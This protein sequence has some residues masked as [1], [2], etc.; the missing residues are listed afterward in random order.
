MA[1]RVLI[2]LSHCVEEHDQLSL[3]S[4]LGYEC[5]SLGGYIDPAHPHEALRPGL[6]DVPCVR[7]VKDAV[8]AL[9]TDDNLGQAQARI[10]EPVLDW[11]GDS[12]VILFH[13]HLHRLFGQWD[14]LRDFRR[15]GGRIIWRTVGQSV[16]NNEA[17][18]APY[19]RDGLEVVRYSPR[20]RHIP[21]YVGED[22]LIRFYKDPLEWRGW[23]GET[24]VVTNFTQGLARRAVWCNVGFWLDATRGLPAQPAGPESEQ[25]P[26]G[27]GPLPLDEMKAQ[28]RKARAYLYTGTQPAS[29]TLG[30][31]EALMTGTPMIS[32]G[33]KHMQIF[34][35]YGEELFEAHELVLPSLWTDDP[36]QAGRALRE[37]LNDHDLARYI[38]ARQRERAIETFGKQQVAAAWRAY[39]G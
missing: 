34:Q 18:A 15:R 31:I 5:A 3:L 20:E 29:V 7:E 12:G 17:E 21:G 37:L 22:A 35:P 11:L 36:D 14:H 27:L 24:E 39:L 16:A 28:L 4:D 13:H 9:G 26:G 38:S 25:L 33:P 6:P 19:R 30:F 1:K 2:C 8:D 10:P 32:I 23:T